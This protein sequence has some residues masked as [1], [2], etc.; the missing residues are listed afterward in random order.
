VLAWR[1]AYS[2]LHFVM[3]AGIVFTAV[4]VK[5]TIARVDEPLATIAAIAFGGGIALYLTGLNLFRL[6]VTHTVSRR[7]WWW[8]CWRARS[9]RSAGRRPP[10]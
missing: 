6:R 2:H 10:C 4:G 9:S 3:V 5:Q 7:G 8:R 1:D